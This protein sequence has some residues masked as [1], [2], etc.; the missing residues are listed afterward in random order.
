[1]MGPLVV[2]ATTAFGDQ[3]GGIEKQLGIT[4]ADDSYV[5]RLLVN[6]SQY[7]LGPFGPDCALKVSGVPSAA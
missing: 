5:R 7:I 3:S 4:K 2:F 6:A 1:M